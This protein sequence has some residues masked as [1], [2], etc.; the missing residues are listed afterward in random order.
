[1]LSVLVSML[2]CLYVCVCGCVG[3][4]GGGGV[5]DVCICVCT[6]LEFT[7]NCNNGLIKNKPCATN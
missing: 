4:G 7:S 6:K 3:G 5:G 2:V 1:M